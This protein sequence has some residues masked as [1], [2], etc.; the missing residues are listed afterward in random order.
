MALTYSKLN[1]SKGK[2]PTWAQL[3]LTNSQLHWSAPLLDSQVWR[4]VSWLDSC[5]P[6]S[7]QTIWPSF[8]GQTD[9]LTRIF[10][11]VSLEPNPTL[12]WTHSLCSLL[13]TRICNGPS[14]PTPPV[15]GCLGS[16]NF[17]FISLL[18][19]IVASHFVPDSPPV[20]FGSTVVCVIQKRE[21]Q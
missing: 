15:L 21:M 9:S 4:S 13:W 19:V 14:N 1:H 3:Y 16:I 12:W 17:H 5:L 10:Y 20:P 6:S 7:K 18:L 11:H 2:Q 8:Y